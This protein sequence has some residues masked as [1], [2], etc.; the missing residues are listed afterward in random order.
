MDNKILMY[1]GFYCSVALC[2]VY[3]TEQRYQSTVFML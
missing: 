2:F 3:S 1:R